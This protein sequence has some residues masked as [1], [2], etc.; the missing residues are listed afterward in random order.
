[1]VGRKPAIEPREVVAAIMNF[2]ER[3]LMNDDGDNRSK[4]F[5]IHTINY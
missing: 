4:Y 1:M 3:V 5:L 2:K